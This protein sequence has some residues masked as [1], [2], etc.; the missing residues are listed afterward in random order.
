MEKTKKYKIIIT[1][2]GT[3]GHIFPLLAIIR[4]LKKIIS[5]DFLEICFIGPK[6]NITEKYIKEEGIV[7]R[8]IFTGKIR[9]YK[10]GFF[11]NILDVLFKIPLGV[12]QSF[13]HIYF[14]SPDLILSKGGHGSLPAVLVGSF[15]RV[16]I[17]IHESDSVV[18]KTN[19]Y[20][21]RFA[22]E[23]FTSF[24][25]TLGV[26]KRKMMVVGNPIRESILMGTKEEAKKRF[27]LLDD[28]PLLVFLGGSQGS[29]RIN[30]LFLS[31][32]TNILKNFEV[33]HQCG[34]DN[35]KQ[36]FAE[37]NAII[38]DDLM[39]KRY[40]PVS[41][42]NE[43]D[44]KSLYASADLIISRAGSGS[45]FEIAG[46]G[47]ASFLIPLSE[48]AQNHQVQNAY[49]YSS[50]KSAVVFEEENLSSHFFLGKLNEI[51]SPIE[52]IKMMEENA[53]NFARPRAGHIVAS[54]IKEY[55][56]RNE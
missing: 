1:G 9:R 52:Q 26:D 42:L 27:N 19:K 48:S 7:T 15:F 32:S 36:V 46:S 17:I 40:H 4:E 16:P 35:Y 3:G 21:Q 43:E 13:F 23:I 2:G 44:L 33:V 5:Q 51:F 31:M 14:Y 24:P 34:E 55:L 39:K 54:Y 25:D 20:L 10:E 18:G 56:T 22:G 41:F 29:I 8:Y 11:Q 49:Q 38:T 28:K 45:I 37:T 47:R 53:R 30:E 50:T 12:I 6:N